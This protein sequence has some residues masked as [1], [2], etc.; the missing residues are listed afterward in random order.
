MRHASLKVAQMYLQQSSC[1]A[2][3]GPGAPRPSRNV[4]VTGYGTLWALYAARIFSL[5]PAAL[6]NFI[7][8]IMALRCSVG[9]SGY[10]HG[11]MR[12]MV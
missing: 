8:Y 2:I 3:D 12:R 5:L 11:G 6:R 10:V 4:N 1:V 9:G 7:R